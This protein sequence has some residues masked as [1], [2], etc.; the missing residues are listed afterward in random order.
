M[1]RW[2]TIIAISLLSL[3][4]LMPVTP[5]ALADQAKTVVTIGCTV[6]NDSA[7]ESS[8]ELYDNVAR[9]Q[10]NSVT[11]APLGRTV[12]TLRST[13]DLSDGYGSFRVR[14]SDSQTWKKFNLIR[15]GQMRTLN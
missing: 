1:K 14:K 6:I 10:I 4:V 9:M 8:F 15:N 7:F 5:A 13:Q 2:R 12:I 11:L 3:T